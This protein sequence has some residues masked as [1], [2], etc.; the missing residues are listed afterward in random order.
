MIWDK[1]SGES[2]PAY[3]AFRVFLNQRRYPAVAQQVGKQLS[4][5]K[6]WAKRHDWRE[7]ADAYDSELNRKA[8]EKAS[9]EYAA[10]IQRQMAVGRMLQ[11]KG[12][13][14]IQAMDLTSLPAKYLP[15]LLQAIK[16]GAQLERTARELKHSEPQ[17]D[18]FVKTLEKIDRRFE[19]DD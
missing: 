16:T 6:R 15:A 19:D 10:M 1:Q 2:Y 7:R 17:T 11:A 12:A 13:N 4:L 14:A 5:I 3:E 18:L 8:L 9:D